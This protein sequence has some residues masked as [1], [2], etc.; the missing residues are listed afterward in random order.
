[1]STAIKGFRPPDEKY[2]RMCNVFRACV[3]AG[4]EPPEE[5]TLFFGGEPPDPRGV[6]VTIDDA[7]QE[8]EDDSREGYEVTIKKLPPDV[9]IIRFFNQ[10]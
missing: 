8:Y 1:M 3:E 5:I 9:T 10:W 7:V 6:E 2:E 4:L